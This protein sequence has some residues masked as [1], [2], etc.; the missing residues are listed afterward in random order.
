MT[1]NYKSKAF[2]VA[3]AGERQYRREAVASS[4][5]SSSSIDLEIDKHAD[6][7]VILKRCLEVAALSWP[8]IMR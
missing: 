7:D 5:K 6:S 3:L 4:C 2:V 8:A 1:C